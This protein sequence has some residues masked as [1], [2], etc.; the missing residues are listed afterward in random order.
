MDQKKYR[1]QGAGHKDG[2][3]MMTTL[4]LRKTICH[5]VEGGNTVYITVVDVQR[6]FETVWIYGL[7]Y[8]L[9]KKGI[10]YRLWKLLHQYY[11][12]VQCCVYIGDELSELFAVYQGVNAIVSIV[13]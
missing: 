2:S 9:Y 1:L 8:Q 4:L 3:S 10:D 13:C 6:A 7:F 5:N 12:D 11:K